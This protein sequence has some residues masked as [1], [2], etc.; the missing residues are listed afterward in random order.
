M[1]EPRVKL[2]LTAT[3][4]YSAMLDAR[5]VITALMKR[6]ENNF[7]LIV[8]RWK[9]NLVQNDY[10]IEN[11]NNTMK[12]LTHPKVNNVFWQKE[13]GEMILREIYNQ[14]QSCI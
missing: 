13:K 12:G 5:A 14:K 3:R 2:L 1:S 7:Q 10:E 6:P 4:P 9:I 11:Q 8:G